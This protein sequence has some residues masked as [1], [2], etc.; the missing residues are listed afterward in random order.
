MPRT[1][2][3][4]YYKGRWYASKFE[5]DIAKQLYNAKMKFEYEKEA[6]SYF[7]PVPNAVCRECECTDVGQWKTYTPDFFL[8][9][10]IVLEAK[11][12]LTVDMRNRLIAAIVSNPWLDLRLV[13]QYDNKLTRNAKMRYSEWA[14]KNNIPW[15]VKEIPTEWLEQT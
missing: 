2:N 12:K 7:F 14:T 3:V 1:R 10:G 13:F 8:A 15:T 11:G 9:N 4:K 5:T 6:V